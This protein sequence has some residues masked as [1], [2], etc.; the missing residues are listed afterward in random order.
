[1]Q[2]FYGVVTQKVA[3][4]PDAGAASRIIKDLTFWQ[5]FAPNTPD[6]LA[7]IDLQQRYTISFWDAMIIW[8]ALQLKCKRVWSEDLSSAQLYEG[9]PVVNPFKNM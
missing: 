5:L 3:R 1:L 7:A 4:P 2:E 9:L 8:S 6:V